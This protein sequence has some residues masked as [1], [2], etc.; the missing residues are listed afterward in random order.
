MADPSR[1]YPPE[2]SD[3]GS[4]TPCK[5]KGEHPETAMDET[6]DGPR[7]YLCSTE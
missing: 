7:E 1:A 5:S 3:N 6:D 4:I 2:K